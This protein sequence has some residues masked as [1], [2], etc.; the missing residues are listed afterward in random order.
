[1]FIEKKY[2]CGSQWLL[3]TT[4]PDYTDF[5]PFLEGNEQFE[6][7]RE[8]T[9]FGAKQYPLWT[10]SSL[11]SVYRIKEHAG[12]VS[13]KGWD[14]VFEKIVAWTQAKLLH[15]RFL[16][17]LYPAIS[18]YMD[19]E[20]DG[21]QG[22]HTHDSNSITQIIYFDSPTHIEPE[23]PAKVAGY[24]AFYAMMC[25]QNKHKYITVNGFPGRCIIMPGNIYHGVYPVKSTP[26][27]TLV[28][29]YVY[30]TK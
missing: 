15:N 29:D 9:A 28:I 26:R 5:L 22:M 16:H 24:G 10:D 20:Q 19:Y 7:S 8:T 6:Y 3:D 18:W 11:S 25:S 4:Y 30:K 1:M 13:A 2:V 17:K 23:S 12:F 14:P 27:R 21:W